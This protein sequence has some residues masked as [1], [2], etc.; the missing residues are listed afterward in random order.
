MIAVLTCDIIASRT[1]SDA[2]RQVLDADLRLA[3]KDT[4]MAIPQAKANYLSFSVIQGDEF[5]FSIEAP[6]FFYH[7]LIMFR[8]RLALSSL[9]PMPSFRAGIGFGSR[10]IHANTSYQMDGSAYHH[11]RSALNS[12]GEPSFKNRLSAVVHDKLPVT[13]SLNTMLAFCDAIEQSWSH[14]QR[15]AIALAF[16]NS[17]SRQIAAILQVS[18][19]NVD[20]LLKSAKWELICQAMDYFANVTGK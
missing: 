12:F 14:T 19:Q 10:S 8:N 1:Y 11:S 9:K 4:C 7:F 13:N 16:T 15:N 2:H 17:S 20:K 6:Q 3:F 18:R 5:Q